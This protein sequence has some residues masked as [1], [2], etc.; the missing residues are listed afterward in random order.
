MFGVEYRGDVMKFFIEKV[1]TLKKKLDSKGVYDVRFLA[2]MLVAV[3]SISVFWNGAKI[4]Q[5]NYELSQKVEQIIQANEVLELE[6]SNKKL[7]NEYLATDTFAELTT[8]R[9]NGMA[10]PGEVVY[11]VPEEVALAALTEQGPISL[12]QEVAEKPQ[13]QRNLE[14]WLNIYFGS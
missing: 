1:D 6:N 4:I 10:A 7:V 12:N 9:V 11:I 14:A 3:I 13:Y 5:Q 2:L 8:R